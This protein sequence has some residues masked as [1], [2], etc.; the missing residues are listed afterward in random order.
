MLRFMNILTFTKQATF[1]ALNM[2]LKKLFEALSLNPILQGNLVRDIPLANGANTVEHLLGRKYI[3]YI[4]TRITAN[5]VVWETT[6]NTQ[7]D[8]FIIL[9]TSALCT[10]DIYFF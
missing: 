9:N 4:V 7:K 5:T 3:G 1:D 2:H 10:A 6:T 8:L